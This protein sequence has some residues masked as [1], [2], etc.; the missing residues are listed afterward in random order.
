MFPQNRWQ[1]EGKPPNICSA[2]QQEECCLSQNV[3]TSNYKKKEREGG[4]EDRQIDK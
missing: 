3:R 2:V 1:E 4:R